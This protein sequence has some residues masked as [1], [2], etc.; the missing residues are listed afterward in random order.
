VSVSLS[1]LMTRLEAAV[2]AVSSVPSQAQYQQC[3]EDAVADLSERKPNQKVYSISI[4]SGTGDYTLPTDFVRPVLLESLMATS[5]VWITATGLIPV[6]ADVAEIY[7]Y[8]GQTLTITPT[9]SY[10]ASRR[11]WYAA[12]HVLNSSNAYPDMTTSEAALALLKA[13][14]L[15]LGLLGMASGSSG[16]KYSIG[17]EVVDKSGLAKG[18]HDQ[19]AM[20]EGR[21]E[22]GLRAAVGPFGARGSDVTDF[23]DS[24]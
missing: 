3:V 9:P 5:G 20:L 11:L 13:Q 10:T 15:A 12:G 17:D 4:V 2:P 22:K 14:A 6:S 24:W 21:Y 7:T 23:L 19:A 18:Y 16:W 1:T 8:A